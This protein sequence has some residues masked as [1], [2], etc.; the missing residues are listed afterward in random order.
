MSEAPRWERHLQFDFVG[1]KQRALRGPKRAAAFLG[2]AERFLEGEFPSSLTVTGRNTRIALLPDPLPDDY[3]ETLGPEFRHWII[4]NCLR[5]LDQF[6]SLMLDECWD[7]IEACRIVSGE[8]PA[9]YEWHRIE[10]RTN[11][12]AKHKMVLQEIGR[13]AAPHEEDNEFLV[14]LSDARNLISHNLGL[15]DAR[16]APDG[17][18]RVRWLHLRS[19]IEAAGR[20]Y[21]LDEVEVPFAIP[22]D[23]G[24]TAVI[25]FV[26]AER[27]FS[28]GERVTLTSHELM[29][30]ALHYEI[31]IERLTLVMV[32][33]ARQA[34]VPFRESPP[35]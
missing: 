21:I 31:M 3:A 20:T 13:F 15:V 17:T 2:M 12:A 18:M 34:G 24:G 10:D 32:E 16:R 28:L 26:A 14:T 30:I 7:I 19:A 9:N 29:Q 25:E 23:E 33:H 27:E 1:L 11:V 35:T 4:T 6:L 5:E 8:R 22:G